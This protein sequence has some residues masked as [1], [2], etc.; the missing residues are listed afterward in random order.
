M[1]DEL[2]LV[3]GTDNPFRD[4]GLSDPDTKR[5]KA[6]LAAEIVRILRER[7]LSG[8][9]AARLAGVQE[10]DVSRIRNPDLDRFTIDRSQA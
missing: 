2:D 1:G 5:M 10:A 4:V 3:R 7:D 8:A 6:D 9:A